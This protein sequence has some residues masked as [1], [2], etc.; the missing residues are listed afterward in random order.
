MSV[1]L[2]STVLL[3]GNSQYYVVQIA[4]TEQRNQGFSVLAAET[5]QFIQI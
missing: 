5:E 4:R 1:E 3:K 2:P